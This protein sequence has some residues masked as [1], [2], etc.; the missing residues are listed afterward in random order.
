MIVTLILWL[1]P[2]RRPLGVLCLGASVFFVGRV[3]GSPAADAGSV[4]Y[5]CAS[6]CSLLRGPV[7]DGPRGPRTV[8]TEAEE[9]ETRPRTLTSD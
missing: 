4:A 7:P 8:P 9:S 1:T 5:V 6:R 2:H 3:L